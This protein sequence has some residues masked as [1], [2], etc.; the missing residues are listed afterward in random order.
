MTM[1]DF[2][3]ILSRDLKLPVVD[4]T[5]LTGAFNFTLRWKW[6]A[7]MLEPDDAVAE[8]KLKCPRQS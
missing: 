6:T 3:G 7:T 4:R 5:G 2:A 8:L 1:A